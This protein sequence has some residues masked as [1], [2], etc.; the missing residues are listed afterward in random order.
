MAPRVKVTKED[1]VQTAVSLVR[2]SGEEP[3]YIPAER[4]A[5]ENAAKSKAQGKVNAAP[6]KEDR[7][8]NDRK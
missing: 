4:R 6:L 5:A 2:E 1:I 7:K 8:Q 3:D